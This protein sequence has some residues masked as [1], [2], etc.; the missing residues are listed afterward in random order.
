V[1]LV[2]ARIFTPRLK[3]ARYDDRNSRLLDR[4]TAYAKALTAVLSGSKSWPN[5]V[6]LSFIMTPPLPDY[7]LEEKIIM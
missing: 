6:F 7:N 3:V 1:G 2:R 5:C 4:C